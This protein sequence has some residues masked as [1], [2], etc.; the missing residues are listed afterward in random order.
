MLS[1]PNPKPPAQL[2]SILPE[3]LPE[4]ARLRAARD[5]LSEIGEFRQCRAAIVLIVDEPSRVL[6][7]RLTFF[8]IRRRAALEAGNQRAEIAWLTQPAGGAVFDN[9]G[10]PADAGGQHRETKRHRFENG[11]RHRFA[12]GGADGGIGGPPPWPQI[13]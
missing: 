13:A 5:I 10:D 2:A 4:P 9:F 7:A 11:G 3:L 6:A 1:L 12:L 8:R